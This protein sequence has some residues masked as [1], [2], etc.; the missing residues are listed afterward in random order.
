[1]REH[2]SPASRPP[3]SDDP[4]AG[5]R[6]LHAGAALGEASAAAILAHGRGGSAQG[7]L[8]LAREIGGDDVAWIAP[9]AVGGS[10]YPFSFLAPIESNEP[11]LT[12]AL[13]LLERL[14][15]RCA[16][17]GLAPYRVVLGGF[18]Q[19]ACLSAEYAARRARRYGGIVV[20]SGGLIGPQGTPRAYRGSLARTPALLG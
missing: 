12:S 16:E 20:L 17:S 9:E 4:H 8:D 13:A 1:M 15:A 2:G 7:M 14:V 6:V 3:A 11:F 18:W 19:G 10:W 5:A